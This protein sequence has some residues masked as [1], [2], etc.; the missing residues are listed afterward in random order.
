MTWGGLG[1]VAEEPGK[2]P[3]EERGWEGVGGVGQSSRGGVCDQ[4]P[5]RGDWSLRWSPCLDLWLSLPFFF[6]FFLIFIIYLFIYLW[7]HWVFVAEHRLSLVVAGR[8]SSLLWCMSFSLQWLL[9]LQSTSSRRTG[10]SSCGLW[11]LERRLSSCG[12]WA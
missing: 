6:F 7:L 8:G 9:L 2:R 11:A 4:T 12:A 5:Q 3:C 10:F 1:K